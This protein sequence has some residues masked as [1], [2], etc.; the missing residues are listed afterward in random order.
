MTQPGDDDLDAP[1]VT[2]LLHVT[3]QPE[4]GRQLLTFVTKRTY[5]LDRK[6]GGA[7]L[8]LADEQVPL[9]LFPELE[10][11]EGATTLVEDADFL[12]PKA[13]TDLVL[14]GSAFSPSPVRERYVA[15]AVG[16]AA[17]R[18]RVVGERRAEV[19]PAGA[20]K[21]PTPE[22]FTELRLGWEHAY[23]G[24]DEHARTLLA[25]PDADAYVGE[26]GDVE[27]PVKQ[28]GV[29]AY[30]RNGVGAGYF[31]DLDRSRA[32][33]ARLPRIE[34][35]SDLLTPERFFVPSPLHWIDA[36]VSA[37]FG[38]Q[39]YAWYPRLV[40]AVGPVLPFVPPSKPLREVTLGCG[41]D[42]P[43]LVAL[44]WSGGFSA[45][46][47]AKGRARGLQGAAPG[48]STKLRGDELVILQGLDRA[49]D[50]LSFSLPGEAPQIELRVP[51]LARTFSPAVRLQTVRLAMERGLV[52]LTWVAAVPLAARPDDDWLERCRVRV[53]FR[54]L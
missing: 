11:E 38:W 15:L 7:R 25:P 4:T 5:A 8:C 36:P 41:D 54:S 6:G 49:R 51:E 2:E 46:Q 40:R 20:V 50:E 13:L 1:R 44:D 19:S 39:H 9:V 42:L 35:P 10:G 43:E 32:D 12:A 33:G 34:D 18:F 23:G 45:D 53:A 47:L 37:G 22:P 27:P 28:R 48:L 30:P 17:R 31:V 52:S 21:F 24:Y 16:D 3:Q 14:T 26:D 29:F